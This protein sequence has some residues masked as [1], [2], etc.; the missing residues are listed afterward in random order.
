MHTLYELKCQVGTPVK[1]HQPVRPC[2]PLKSCS[3]NV[4]VSTPTENLVT[5]SDTMLWARGVEV[6]KLPS[7]AIVT[8]H[9]QASICLS[10]SV[11]HLPK[12]PTPPS[13][14]PVLRDV[15][16]KLAHGTVTALVGRSGAGKST[17]AAMLSRFY[18]PQVHSSHMFT[19]H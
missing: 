18:E 6:Q 8:I 14:L 9:H 5:L 16:L 19:W 7:A 11:Q 10:F 13:V 3:C 2:M 4:S 1:P 12:L 15:S 17:V